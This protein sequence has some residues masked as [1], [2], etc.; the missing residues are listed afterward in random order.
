M[1]SSTACVRFVCFSYDKIEEN[2]CLNLSVSLAASLQFFDVFRQHI[3]LCLSSS[4]TCNL[5]YKKKHS[6]ELSSH[7]LHTYHASRSRA[8]CSCQERVEYSGHKYEISLDRMTKIFCFHLVFYKR[9]NEI[10]TQCKWLLNN[11]HI[12]GGFWMPKHLEIK[13]ITKIK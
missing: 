4:L 10:T 3:W 7:P 6:L 13:K 9:V 5:V 1:S 8:P 12:Y 2:L 11:I